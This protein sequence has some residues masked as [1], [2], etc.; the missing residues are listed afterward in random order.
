M[1]AGFIATCTYCYLNGERFKGFLTQ[2]YRD[3]ENK[4]VSAKP[5]K[6]PNCSVIRANPN[7]QLKLLVGS[8]S[9]LLSGAVTFSATINTVNIFRYTENTLCPVWLATIAGVFGFWEVISAMITE[10]RYSDWRLRS[11]DGEKR[12]ERSEND[13]N[14]IIDLAEDGRKASEKSEHG[15]VSKHWALD[16][17]QILSVFAARTIIETIL[18]PNAT[19][20]RE[21]LGSYAICF[22]TSFAFYLFGLGTNATPFSEVKREK[23]IENKVARGIIQFVPQLL[24]FVG[25]GYATEK[26]WATYFRSKGAGPH[27][28]NVGAHMFGTLAAVTFTLLARLMID[29]LF[30]APWNETENSLTDTERAGDA[31][32]PPSYT[33]KSFFCGGKTP[34]DEE[35]TSE[36]DQ[37]K[38]F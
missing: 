8:L 3:M 10:V 7:L 26:I 18:L 23:L 30:S 16:S 22:M 31:E 27:E 6:F 32:T 15:Y 5:Y 28:T 4:D 2:P 34:L 1:V 21:I 33:W 17:T 11:K 13:E 35:Q 20:E 36:S 25:S 19:F 29:Y 12:F 9:A 37:E 38:V 24:V 14:K